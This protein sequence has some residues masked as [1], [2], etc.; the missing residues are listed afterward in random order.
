MQAPCKDCPDRRPACHDS[1][2]KFRAFREYWDGIREIRRKQEG[3]E[4]CCADL[5]INFARRARA[6][7]KKKK[8]R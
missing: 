1:C 5:Q 7:Q 8:R 2:P 6:E 4:R 3:A